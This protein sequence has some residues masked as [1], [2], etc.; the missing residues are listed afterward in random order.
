MSHT[1]STTQPPGTQSPVCAQSVHE[2]GSSIEQIPSGDPPKHGGLPPAPEDD[3]PVAEDAW[4]VDEVAPPPELALAA[5]PV[6]V[7]ACPPALLLAALL[8]AVFSETSPPQP[9]QAANETSAVTPRTTSV[10]RISIA[11]PHVF[12]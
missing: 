3:A 10:A 7:L 12:I 4:L 5:L 6:L 11:R 9:S 1:P 2:H 8:L